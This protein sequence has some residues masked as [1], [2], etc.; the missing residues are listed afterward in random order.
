MW[1]TRQGW[2][3]H[4]SQAHREA[5]EVEWTSRMAGPLAGE[6][7]AGRRGPKSDRSQVKIQ[8]GKM[9]FRTYILIVIMN[10]SGRESIRPSFASVLE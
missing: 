2:Y 10:A 9:E 1:F 5:I 7:E 6:R 3:L 8:T 4:G